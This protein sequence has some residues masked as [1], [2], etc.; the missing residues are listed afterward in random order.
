MKLLDC[1]IRDG[2]YYNFWDFD[3]STV[4]SYL[5]YI[6]PL[7]IEYIEIG[8]RSLPEGEYLG[9]YFYLPKSRIK[10]IH[11][12]TTKSLAVILNEKNTRLEDLEKLIGGL[13]GYIKMVRIAIDPKNLSRALKLIAEIKKYGFEVAANVMYLSKWDLSDKN[14]LEAIQNL[15][16]SGADVFYLVDSYGGIYPNE[17][18]TLISEIKNHTKVPLGFHGHNNLELSLIN[19]IIAIENN[20]EFIDSTIMGMG[21]GA[22]NLKTELLLTHLSKSINLEVNFDSLGKLIEQFQDLMDKYQ[23]G[24]NLPYMISGISNLPQKQVME[25]ITD[26]TYSYTSITN[27]LVSRQVDK[28][29][30]PSVTS[31]KYKFNQSIILGGG[32]SAAEN[33]DYIKK[34]IEINTDTVLIFASSRFSDLYSKIDVPKFFILVGDEGKRVLNSK[35]LSE[36]QTPI[37]IVPKGPRHIESFIPRIINETD[38]YE[39]DNAIFDDEFTDNHTA[40]ALEISKQISNSIYII[41]YDGFSGKDIN[42]KQHRHSILNYRIFDAFQNRT[43][44]ILKSLTQTKYSNLKIE[45]IYSMLTNA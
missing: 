6:N 12:Q 7:P 37:A 19:S 5:K 32:P 39:S 2:G 42:P 38:I 44:L 17:L 23:W 33:V 35:E 45:S 40:M 30:F 4:S 1:T 43:N 9:E 31:I 22:G 27:A 18:A 16:N 11:S 36:N 21:R 25:W 28:R 26:K 34:L 41:G 8:Y 24:T 29:N 10:D 20:V 13:E 15:D 14:F 3:K